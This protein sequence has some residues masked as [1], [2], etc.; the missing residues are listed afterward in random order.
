MDD[1]ITLDYGSGGIKTSDFIDNLLVPA[2]DNTPLNKL[3]DGA[4]LDG[5]ERLVFS[6]DSFV[7]SPWKFPGGNIGRLCV[8]GTVNDIAMAGGIPKY[9]SLSFILEEGFKMWDLKEIIASI[10]DEA[11][12]AQVMIVT[13]DT[14]VVEHGKGDGIYINTSGIGILKNPRLGK[15]YIRP[16]DG[17]I[18]S[19]SVGCHGASVMM[20]RSGLLDG[21]GPLRSDCRILTDLAVAA[22]DA[23]NVRILRD[24]TRG[25]I[26][27]VLNEFVEDS[28]LTVELNETAIP[29]DATVASACDLLGLDPLYCACEGRMLAVVAPEDVPS[30]LDALHRLSGGEKAACIG[31]IT[32]KRPGQV[33]LNTSLGGRRLL[34]KLSGHQLPRIC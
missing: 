2:F 10:A 31:T 34:G 27:T 19:G 29:V 5:A 1:I 9:L 30:V 21:D 3:A 20:A 24:P 14:K 11:K 12:K 25:G 6:T 13:G 4:V 15:E 22:Q 18:V 8:C 33:I 32:Q 16:G 23:G 7:V 26:A 17:V 28:P